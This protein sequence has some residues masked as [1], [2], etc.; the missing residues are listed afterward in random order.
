[1]EI[2][3]NL[4]SAPWIPVVDLDG[5]RR[6]VGIRDALLEAHRIQRL[7][8]LSPLAEV[9]VHRLLLA[10]LHRALDG[11]RDSIDVAEIYQAGQL[12]EGPIKSYL[13]RWEHRFDLFH[14]THP[15]YQV[16]DLPT[17]R[18][19]PW[20][21][22]P[23]E[24]ASGHNPTLFDHTMDDSPPPAS[25]AEAALALLVHQSFALCGTIQR[26]GVTSGT[27]GPLARAALFLPQGSNLF[28]TLLLNLPP[29]DGEGDQPLWEREPYRRADVEGGRAQAML[30]GRTRTYTWMSRAVRLLPEDDGHVRF[31]AYGPGVRPIESPDLDPMCAYRR[32]DG[33]LSPYQLPTDRSFWWRDFEALLPGQD[34]WQPPGVLEHTRSVLSDLGRTSMLFPLTVAGQMPDQENRFNIVNVRREVY[35]LA[36]RTLEPESAS[37]IRQA[38]KSARETDDVLRRA[39][40]E[41]ASH[42]LPGAGKEVEKDRRRFVQSLPLY[43][44]YWSALERRFPQFL[45]ELIETGPQPALEGWSAAVLQAAR[46]AWATTAQAVGTGPRHLRALA[47]AEGVLRRWLAGRAA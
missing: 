11:P 36:A 30:S 1:V 43:K 23:P 33:Q 2:S 42:L 21:R 9:A 12:P 41:L 25:P 6:L 35:P 47:E 24:F 18:P 32:K 20:T 5:A 15:F 4:V 46:S 7:T 17:D 39:A 40:W 45:T 8:T 38:L 28:E 10:V 34:D 44:V 14:P 3:F 19:S 16:P 27:D 31:I 29:Y 13:E 26:L 37:Y 22:L